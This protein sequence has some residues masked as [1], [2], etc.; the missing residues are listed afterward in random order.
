MSLSK[1][2][3]ALEA[4]VSLW[5]LQG[6]GCLAHGGMPRNGGPDWEMVAELL[7]D[8]TFEARGL[9]TDARDKMHP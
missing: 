7:D 3:Q 2:L 5:T 8:T 9:V 6:M 1:R 4:D